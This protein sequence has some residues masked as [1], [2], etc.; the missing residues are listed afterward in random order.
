[1]ECYIFFSTKDTKFH[2]EQVEPVCGFV[3]FVEVLLLK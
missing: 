2:E 3:N 1:M